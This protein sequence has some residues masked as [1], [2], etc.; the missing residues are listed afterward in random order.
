LADNLDSWRRER[1][2][3]LT[4]VIKWQGTFGAPRVGT[5]AMAKLMSRQDPAQGRNFRVTHKLDPVPSLPWLAAG[6]RHITPAYYITTDNTAVPTA[7][8]FVMQTGTTFENPIGLNLTED[9]LAHVHYFD[10]ISGCYANAS[11]AAGGIPW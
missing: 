11:A 7:Q 9:G 8:D 1:T 2:K 6:Y 10:H 4:T 5:E 3:R